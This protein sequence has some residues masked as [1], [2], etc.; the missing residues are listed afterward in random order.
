MHIKTQ[1]IVLRETN[2]KEADKILNVLTPSGKIT[3]SARGARRKGSRISAACQLFALSEM[4]LFKYKDRYSVNEAEVREQFLGLRADIKK[5]ALA[6]YFMELLEALAN[7]EEDCSEALALALN[8]LY[9]LDADLKPAELIK[10]VF[11]LRIMALSGFEPKLD[12]CAVCGDVNPE[13]PRLSVTH[14]VLCCARCRPADGV[15]MPLEAG[16]LDAMRYITGAQNKKMFS[17]RLSD[18]GLKQLG[19]AAETFVQVQLERS[20]KTLDFYKGLN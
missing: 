1:G 8:S 20:F 4:E 14:G 2:Y 3:V 10:P 12:C 19:H 16:A 17:F 7:E 6:A 15:A 18:V 9:A 11:E 13:G 5:F